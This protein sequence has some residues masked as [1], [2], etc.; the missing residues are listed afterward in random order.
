MAEQGDDTG[1]EK[2]SATSEEMSDSPMLLSQ[3]WQQCSSKADLNTALYQFWRDN[4][5]RAY[6]SN[7]L[8]VPEEDLMCQEKLL[9]PLEWFICNG[10][11]SLV[12][13]QLKK[14]DNPPQLC[15]RV[16]KMGEP[17]YSCRDCAMDPTCVLCIECFQKSKH[18]THRY[19][20]NTS[21]GGGYCDCGDIEAWKSDPYCSIHQRNPEK[22]AQDPLEHLPVDMQSYSSALFCIIL[23]YCCDMLLQDDLEVPVEDLRPK[24]LEDTYCTMLF[25]DEIHTYEQVIETLR[26]AVNCT[27]KEAVD[28]A[29]IVDREG[30]STVRNGLYKDCERART[31]IKRNTGLHDAKSLKVQ[32][33]HSTVVAHQ[34]YALKLLS[35]LSEVASYA[36]GLRQL[37][38]QEL[39]KPLHASEY[40]ILEQ[41]M[42]KDTKLWKVARIQWHKL[43]MS[44]L[45]MDMEYKKKF[46]IMF[47]K[48]YSQIL[49]DFA[50]DDHDHVVSVTSLSVQIYTVPTVSRMLIIEHNL[51]AVI[52]KTFVDYTQKFREGPAGGKFRFQ[53]MNLNGLR[54]FQFV[55]ID[56]RYILSNKPEEWTPAVRDRVMDGI[57]VLLDLLSAMHGMDQVV[58]QVGKHIEIEPEWETAFNLQIKLGPCLTLLLDWCVSDRS[59]LLRTYRATM[60]A[61]RKIVHNCQEREVEVADHKTK[62]LVYNV[63]TKPI[64]VHC[65]LVRF[66]AG[67]QL[68][69][70]RYNLSYLSDGLLPPHPL[71]PLELMEEPLRTQ[72]LMAQ[73]NAAM[74]RRNGYSLLNQIYYYQNVACQR[75]MYD[76]DIIML[77]SCACLMDSNDFMIRA[78]DR[79]NLVR[80]LTV[81]FEG[82]STPED[83]QQRTLGLAILEEFLHLLIVLVSERYI[84]GVGQVTRADRVRREVLHQLYINSM[85]HS[86]IV[87]ALPKDH[88][89]ETGVE[90]VINSVANFKKPTGTNSKGLY[91]IKPDCLAEYSPFFYHYS[92][93][94]QSKSEEQQRKR[95]KQDKPVQVACPPLPPLPSPNF[96]NLPHLLDSEVLVSVLHTI[97]RRAVERIRQIYSEQSLQRALFLTGLAVL[98]EKRHAKMGEEFHFLEKAVKGE[99]SL[100]NLLKNLTGNSTV[101]PHK[102]LLAW[103][104]QNIT[105]LQL[106]RGDTATASLAPSCPAPKG[107]DQELLRQ[108]QAERQRRSELAMKKR[109]HAMDQMRAMQ[110]SFIRQNPEFFEQTLEGARE[111]RTASTSSMDTVDMF[112]KSSSMEDAFVALG[113]SHSEP[114]LDETSKVTCILCMEES[115]IRVDG[116]SLV[117]PM[118]VQRSTVLAQARNKD[119][120]NPDELDPLFV[121][122]QLT[123]GVHANTC[124]H[125]M[126]AD[127]WQGYFESLVIKEQRRT[128]RFRNNLSYDLTRHQYLCPLCKTI[129]NTVI[130]LIPP[131]QALLPEEESDTSCSAFQEWLHL[132]QGMVRSG[133]KP[134]QQSRSDPLDLSTSAEGSTADMEGH[135]G[136]TVKMEK[137]DS[138]DLDRQIFTSTGLLETLGDAASQTMET[139]ETLGDAAKTLGDAATQKFQKFCALL[140]GSNFPFSKSVQ[141]MIRMFSKTAYTVGLGVMP[142]D[143]NER[144]SILGWNVCAYSIQSTEVLLRSKG[145]PLFGEMASRQTEGLKALVR[146]AMVNTF[147][148]DQNH[149]QKHV[150]RLLS[151]F[152]AEHA[153]TGPCLLD[154]DMFTLLVSVCLSGA[155]MQKGDSATGLKATISTIPI[156]GHHALRAVLTAHIVQILLTVQIDSQDEE[157]SMDQDGCTSQHAQVML[158]AYT[159]LRTLAGIPVDVQ[160]DAWRLLDVVRTSCLPL[161]RCATIFFRFVTGIPTPTELQATCLDEFEQLCRYLAVPSDLSSLVSNEQE[162]IMQDLIKAWCQ[163]PDLKSQLSD[164]SAD[165][166]RFPMVV[167]RLI[168]LPEDYS[169]LMNNVSMFTCPKASGAQ[170]DSRAP[171]LCLVCGAVVCSQSYCCQT[172]IDGETVGA[173]TS[174]AITCGAGVGLYLR[175]RECQLLMMSAKNK[176]CV[177]QTP[178][179]DEYGEP[180]LNLRRGNPLHL[181]QEHYN[182]LHETWL[183]HSIPSQ[184]A[185]RLEANN[186]LLTIDWQNL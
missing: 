6:T 9:Q 70:G 23:H 48:H 86:E 93:V 149:I 22:P 166:I 59:L 80:F 165:V 11:P 62:C 174:H 16:F 120:G 53:R 26:K 72:V 185:H 85:S 176:G 182:Q 66:L 17:T 79:Y 56:L 126:H 71:S 133:V 13:Q 127:C 163:H 106:M 77:Q 2:N 18:K 58:R 88:C 92:R 181:S 128:F 159:R 115:E 121:S 100:L 60:T 152:S 102:E 122:A 114:L 28:F 32:V 35:W 64:T 81:E 136:S 178:Y 150:V 52:L 117:L 20:M 45:L 54:R 110:R 31:I 153:N 41:I 19:R 140:Q 175:V 97:V 57:T 76:K 7:E 186:S 29:T 14:T 94:D 21:G 172:E 49:H 69:L 164:T 113:P 89:H 161:L 10:D 38:C 43:F 44:T 42:L 30:R 107:Q 177:H 75:E 83:I 61:L 179:L 27:P 143:E 142:D 151:V 8:S 168:E 111:E 46:A 145:K 169:D 156:E 155:T 129:G 67:L 25:N 74:W 148:C 73:V 90:E 51:L 137:L 40:T 139:L 82:S 4:V 55:L 170:S 33:M 141:E 5:P 101:E 15:G 78:L 105:E 116:D 171:A 125:I 147:Y 109:A 104:L 24:T 84:P 184:V 134:P 183:S 1:T 167:N 154:L 173:C 65:T 158:Q 50:E 160:P 87:K 112:L 95:M 12:F 91:E 98:E 162:P 37:Q 146:F 68:E 63:S 144:V 124:G 108:Q 135:I 130:P 47:T 131:L 36:D 132:I 180:D 96:K 34:T 103:V 118:F 3:R 119:L 157:S 138:E 99:P 123:W 39:M